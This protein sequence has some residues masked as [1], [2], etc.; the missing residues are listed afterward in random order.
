[1]TD[2]FD[3][4]VR[5][6]YAETD[7]MR[8]VYYGNFFIWFEL[9]RTEFFRQLGFSYRDME[10]TDG[11]MIVVVEACCRYRSPARY[12]DVLNIRTRLKSVKG[13]IIRFTY[14]ISRPLPDTQPPIEVAEGETTHLVCD[15]QMKTRTLP[16]KYADALETLLAK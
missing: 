16:Q 7:Q 1:M 9:G 8:V 5:V 6:R 14:E 15:P 10:A 4:S 13:P 2:Y 3:T 12:D 11:C